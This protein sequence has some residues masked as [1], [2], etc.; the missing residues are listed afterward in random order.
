MRHKRLKIALNVL[1]Y[2]SFVGAT[3]PRH[4][5]SG[6]SGDERIFGRGEW[7]SGS[8]HLSY[9]ITNLPEPRNA[10]LDEMNLDHIRLTVSFQVCAILSLL[11]QLVA[12][13][14]QRKRVVN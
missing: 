12:L 14:V 8:C 13:D 7:M 4:L 10:L 6:S 9:S 2:A 11:R 5:V 3:I 1:N